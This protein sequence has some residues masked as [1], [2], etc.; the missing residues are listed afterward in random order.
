MAQTLNPHGK[1][2]PQMNEK[3]NNH[4]ETNE[5]VEKSL[6]RGKIRANLVTEPLELW[7]TGVHNEFTTPSCK[8]TPITL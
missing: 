1:L 5:K 4:N 7:L 8:F 2:F 3:N 6:Q